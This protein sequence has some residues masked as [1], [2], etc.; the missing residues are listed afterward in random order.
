MMIMMVMLTSHFQGDLQ[1]PVQ[2]SSCKRINFFKAP[3]DPSFKEI[4]WWWWW[5]GRAPLKV[6]VP[7]DFHKSPVCCQLKVEFRVVVPGKEEHLEPPSQKNKDDFLL[8]TS[9]IAPCPGFYT[10]LCTTDVR[11][12]WTFGLAPNRTARKVFHLSWGCYECNEEHFLVENKHPR[13]PRLF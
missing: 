8:N 10:F 5:T 13:D 3:P 12:C 2:M 1:K 4:H 7:S 9:S 6:S 11:R